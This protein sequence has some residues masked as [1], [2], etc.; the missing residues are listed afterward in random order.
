MQAMEAD[1]ADTETADGESLA[2]GSDDGGVSGSES[3]MGSSYS[4]GFGEPS[5]TL[6]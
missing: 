5:S 1:V 2:G 3:A 6:I 4:G